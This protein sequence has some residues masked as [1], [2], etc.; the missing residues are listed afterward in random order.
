M[1]EQLPNFLKNV[2]TMTYV[3]YDEGCIITQG[4][5]AERLLYL[6]AY[7]FYSQK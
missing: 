3:T 5:D 7:L 1:P 2:P 6:D 4:Q